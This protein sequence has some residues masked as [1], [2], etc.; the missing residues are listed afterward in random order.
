[1][2]IKLLTLTTFFVCA[3][4][5]IPQ[6]IYSQENDVLNSNKIIDSLYTINQKNLILINQISFR[7]RENFEGNN[8]DVRNID[9]K[10]E[11]GYNPMFE[12]TFLFI[13]FGSKT[14][15]LKYKSGDK[16][17]KISVLSQNKIIV[18]KSYFWVPEY[19]GNYYIYFPLESKY[20]SCTS[21]KTNIKIELIEDKTKAIV[22]SEVVKYDTYCE[23]D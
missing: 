10:E 20:F 5:L 13:S 23:T 12:N 17:I 1:M 2:R 9:T 6:N 7:N 19:D 21:P 3:F 15:P 11:Y 18:G 16:R 22:S 14:L 4:Y 8:L